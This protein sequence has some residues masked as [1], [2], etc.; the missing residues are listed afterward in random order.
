[1]PLRVRLGLVFALGTAVVIATVGLGFLLQLR[2][3]LDATL[4]IGLRDRAATL[5][6][7][8]VRDGVGALRLDQDESP[9]QVLTADGRVVATSPALG[10]GPVLDETRRRAAL[11]EPVPRALTFTA[12]SGDERTRFIAEPVRELGQ[13]LVVGTETDISDAA[14]DHVE[15]GL[16]VMGPIAVLIAGVGGWWLA[17][18]A[19]RPVE[20][21][22]R[23]ATEMSERDDDAYL[24]VP[25][26]RDELAALATTM[27]AMLDGLRAALRHERGFVAD[28][29]H[30]M[31]TPLATLR[32]ELELASR[33][34][35]S[36]EE[37]QDAVHGAA[38]ETDRIIRLAE[39]LL[40]LARA[41][42]DRGFLQRRATDLGAVAAAAARAA[43][44]LGQP[45][46]V[47]VAVE[48]ASHLEIDGDPERLRQALDNVLTN[49]VHHSPDGAAV[50]VA[51]SE[52]PGGCHAG[53]TVADR[54]PGFP[55]EFLPHAFERFRRADTARARAGGGTGLGLAIVETIVRAHHGRVDADNQ[56][57]GGAVVEIVLPRGDPASPPDSATIDRHLPVRQI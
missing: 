30:E 40:L 13:I 23:E 55:A 33:P 57:G 37:L 31:R 50:T 47:T 27:N 35:R 9:V 42:D 39:D 29:G 52:R 14:D 2:A 15:K 16:L 44:V 8:L 53:L 7:Q 46:G 6:A 28:A 18:E 54:G 43:S 1:M 24:V 20:R 26:T 38:E 56:D 12:G 41:E 25:Q 22:R 36:R 48:G 51:V 17:G 3:S 49:A 19:L 45:R 10:P 11:R 5:S 32:A 21:M 4:D 34:G